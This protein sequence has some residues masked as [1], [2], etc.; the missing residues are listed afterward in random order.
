MCG[1]L[2]KYPPSSG[3]S[4]SAGIIISS[5]S[6]V[7]RLHIFIDYQNCYRTAR[8]AFG[9]ENSLGIYGQFDPLALA[10]L[11][12]RRRA[13]L[14]NHSLPTATKI[15]SISIYSGI[16]AKRMDLYGFNRC[17]RQFDAWRSLDSRISVIS[18]ELRYFKSPEIEGGFTT[19]QEK[20]IDIALAIDFVGEAM[21]GGMDVGLLFSADSDFKPVLSLLKKKNLPIVAEV[22]AWKTDHQPQ[23]GRKVYSQR[24][25]SDENPKLPFCHWLSLADYS[26]IRDLKDY[27]VKL[28]RT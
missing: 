24:L 25:S 8:R 17:R 9:F 4:L 14:L 1:T 7:E 3:A 22:A 11:L 18:R 20:G 28:R 16:P 10:I 15:D 5:P 21:T 13:P 12:A 23:G 27:G 26:T 6:R 19:G 2:V